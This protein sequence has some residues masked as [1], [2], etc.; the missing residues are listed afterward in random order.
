MKLHPDINTAIEEILNKSIH[1]SFFSALSKDVLP[2]NTYKKYLFQD[3]IYLSF[4]RLSLRLIAERCH[5]SNEKKFFLDCAKSIQCEPSSLV[6]KKRLNQASPACLNY[7]DYLMHYCQKEKIQGITAVFPCYYLYYFVAKALF[8]T[9]KNH[10][11]QD[12]F[13]CYA[14]DKFVQ[15]T[16]QLTLM[17]N[18]CY[19]KTVKKRQLI[20]IIEEGFQFEYDFH[21]TF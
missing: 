4:Y 10:R 8:P 5:N 12:W 1:A 15:Q 6:K 19:S 2:V 14:G 11:H 7:I 21:Q 17:L 13:D 16:K 3:A 20:G 9:R 18:E